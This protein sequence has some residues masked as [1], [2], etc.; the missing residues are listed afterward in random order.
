MN[1]IYFRIRKKDAYVFTSLIIVLFYTYFI[2]LSKILYPLPY[3]GPLSLV[4][5]YILLLLASSIKSS[6]FTINNKRNIILILLLLLINRNMDFKMYDF[7]PFFKYLI[8]ILICLILS[9]IKDWGKYFIKIILVFSLIQAVATIVLWMFPNLAI[10]Y[11]SPLFDSSIRGELL[12]QISNGYATGLTT[13][14]SVNGIYLAIGTGF[15]AVNFY[16]KKKISNAIKFMILF[17]ALLLTA[18]RGPLLFCIIS[19]LL[20]YAI[21]NKVNVKNIAKFIIIVLGIILAAVIIAKYV[22]SFSNIVKRFTNFGSDITGGRQ[23]LYIL[24][25]DMFKQN[26]FWGNGWGS[27]KYFANSSVIGSIYGHDS[28][29]YAHNV[30]LQVLAETG[31]IGFGIYIT[32]IFYNLYNNI[33]IIKITIG[34]NKDIFTYTLFI[35][36]FYLQY[37]MTGN[38]LYDFGILIPY[39]LSICLCISF[40]SKKERSLV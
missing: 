14:Y 7:I 37:S 24:A 34:A 10:N 36:L 4:F 22:P 30:Y 5:A 28:F 38:A 40:Y 20:C 32:F 16:N 13:H 27:Y 11:I 12:R 2:S 9:N 1:I 17:C 29:M 21:Y 18:K 35:Q 3:Q 8:L 6:S 15:A 23:P 19:L 39:L 25:Y 33:K 31:I 26:I